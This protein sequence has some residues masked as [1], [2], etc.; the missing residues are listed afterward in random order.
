MFVFSPSPGWVCLRFSF[1]VCFCRSQEYTKTTR[2]L[3]LNLLKGCQMVQGPL[4]LVSWTVGSQMKKY[5]WC[6]SYMLIIL[7]TLPH[8]PCL[9]LLLQLSMCDHM[10]YKPVKCCKKFQSIR[11]QTIT[12]YFKLFSSCFNYQ[13]PWESTLLESTIKNISTVQQ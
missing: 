3:S 13:I 7:T 4:D 5:R 10:Y 8:I 6:C 11:V 2:L 12:P 9:I 1:L